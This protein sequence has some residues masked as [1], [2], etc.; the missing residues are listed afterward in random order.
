MRTQTSIM[1]YDGL[2]RPNEQITIGITPDKND[3]VQTTSYEGLH[4]ER[5]K[6]LPVPMQTEGQYVESSSFRTQGSRLL[7]RQSSI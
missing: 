2:G 1:Y 5:Q 3:L 4:R 6:W 7:F